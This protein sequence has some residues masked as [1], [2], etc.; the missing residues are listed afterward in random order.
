MQRDH[1]GLRVRQQ[2]KFHRTDGLACGRVQMHH[3]PRI[4]ARHV[5]RGV[6]RE[7]GRI[8]RMRSRHHRLPLNV[9]L[10]KRR[11]RDLL[12]H[13]VIRIDEKMMLRPRNT[14]RQMREDDVVPAIKRDKPVSGGKINADHPFG[15]GHGGPDM[16]VIGRFCG[17]GHHVSLLAICSVTHSAP[18]HRSLS[19]TLRLCGG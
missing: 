8:H 11:S 17:S 9:D 14:R 10:N 7:A 2:A 18:P 15:I 4:I 3:R 1:R 19:K 13:H 6:D 12:K 16:V 5:D